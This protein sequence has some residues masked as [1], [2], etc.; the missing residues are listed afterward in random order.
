MEWRK[1]VFI[2][3]SAVTI[4]KRKIDF[5]NSTTKRCLR[6]DLKVNE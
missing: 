5:P 2:L 4:P 1:V 3:S 6:T